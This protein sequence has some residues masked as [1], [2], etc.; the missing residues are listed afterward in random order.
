LDKG[1]I[2]IDGLGTI[3][4]ELIGADV[5]AFGELVFTTSPSGYIKS[6]TDPSYKGQILVFSF[7]YIGA[8]GTEEKGESSRVMANGA[9][10]SHVPQ[11]K[12]EELSKFLKDQNVPGLI[13]E[14]TRKIVDYIRKY[15][16]K[17]G[18]IGM[19]DLIDPYKNN[20]VDEALWENRKE[21]KA[22][23]L[24]V[25][26]GI[27]G[28]IL[29]FL[30]DLKL[31]VIPYKEFKN[32]IWENYKGIVISNGPGDPSHEKLKSFG[33]EIQNVIGKKPILGICLGHQLIS[34][35]SGLE[36]FKMKFGHRSINHP[37]L[38]LKTEKF[39]IT[40]HNHGFSVKFREGHNLD[41]RFQSLND[42]SVEGLMGDKLLT[43]QFHP[44]GGPGPRDELGIFNDFR[45]MMGI[46]HK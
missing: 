24:V 13:I 11:L 8:Y 43:V 38:D 16:N 23:I 20:L 5:S 30:N 14:N 9:I 39:G 19:T 44:E 32:G 22:D 27:K 4:G 12:K 21:G 1:F 17:L 41:L 25:D 37:V 42:G 35:Y 45:R 33:I 34:L 36:T 31:D 15:G 26:L 2:I 7:P 18:A 28:N 29:E 40:T 6:L 10:F 46:E 3:E